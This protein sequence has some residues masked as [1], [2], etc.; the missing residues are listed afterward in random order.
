MG[1][2]NIDVAAATEFGILVCNTPG[3]LTQATADL[4]WSLLMSAARRI[5]EGDRYARAG[6]FK[7]WAPLLLQG[8]DIFGKTLGIIGAGRIGEAVAQRS[9]GFAMKVV[10]YD[11]RYND[12]M[13]NELGAKK[14]ELDELLKESDFISLHVPYNENTHHLIGEEELALMKNTCVLINTARGRVVEE[15]AL[16]AA[17]KN[18]KIAAAGLDVFYDEPDIPQEIRD[19][20]NIVIVPHIGSATKETRMKMAQLVLDCALACIAK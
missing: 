11:N 8:Q 6:K 3:V 15:K 17:L 2:N 20:E 10:Y 7:G 19:L 13:E 4:A 14:V 12:M 9:S 16:I 18:H 1:Y 5:A